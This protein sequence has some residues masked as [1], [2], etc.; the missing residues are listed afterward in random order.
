M[1]SA[2]SLEGNNGSTFKMKCSFLV[3]LTPR[4]GSVT[5]THPFR[6]VSVDFS[7]PGSVYG[8]SLYL[9]PNFVFLF[10]FVA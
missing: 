6:Y 7:S 9:L 5:S 2:L 8:N 3:K 4:A 1:E 10:V